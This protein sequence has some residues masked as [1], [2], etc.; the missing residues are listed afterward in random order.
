MGSYRNLIEPNKVKSV[1]WDIDPD[2]YDVRLHSLGKQFD[3]FVVLNPIYDDWILNYIDTSIDMQLCVMWVKGDKWIAKKFKGNWIPAD[4]WQ[5][6][7]VDLKIEAIKEFDIVTETNPNL[8]NVFPTVDYNIQPEDYHLEHIWYLDPKYFKGD[9]IWI[10]KIKACAEPR[11]IKDMGFVSPEILD[12]LDVIFI[13]YDEPNADANWQ[14]VLKKVPFAQRVHGVKGIFEAH[15]AA[16]NLAQTDMFWV[17]DGDAEILDDWHFD[18]CPS[19]F[20]RDCVHVW[21]SRNPINELVYGYGGI[22]LFPRQLLLDA[23]TWHIDMTTGLGKI[24][25]MSRISNNTAFN[26]DEF[27]TWRS[28]FRECVKL[29]AGTIKNQIEDESQ[30]RLD[31]WTSV[32]IDKPFGKYAIEGAKAGV[33]FAKQYKNDHQMLKKINDRNWLKEK[34]NE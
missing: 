4:G 30:Y 28:A 16:A 21:S 15:K 8:P 2:S 10:K 23:T 1:R 26:T 19:I 6:I 33:E 5:V 27:S 13:S 31:A 12:E 18:Y 3:E 14:R 9:K 11:G 22:K 32:G 20:N 34:F 24:K 7:E 17:V 29:T 25:V